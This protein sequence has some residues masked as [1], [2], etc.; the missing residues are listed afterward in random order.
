MVSKVN[1][2][3]R[4]ERHSRILKD[5]LWTIHPFRSMYH[6]LNYII[7]ITLVI[8]LFPVYP[9]F[10]SFF[11]ENSVY[12]F[13]RWD[14]DESTIIDSYSTDED[15]QNSSLVWSDNFLS[16]NTLMNSDRDL[17]G[18]NEVVDYEV[19]AWD[20]FSSL[21]YKFWVSNNSIL[22]ANNFDS[23]KVLHPWD[24]IKIPPVSGLIHQVKKWETVAALAKKYSIDEKKILSQN[25]INSWDTLSEW[26]VLII[27]GAIKKVEQPVVAKTTTKI[28]KSTSKTA[29]KSANSAQWW[30]AFT[31]W[32]DSEFIESDWVYE[33]VKRTPKWTFYRWNCTWYVA[34]YKNVDWSWN[35]NQWL[36]NARSKWHTTWSTPGVWSIVV[37]N[38]KWYNPRYWHVWIVIDVTSDSIIVRDM[39]YRRLNEVTVR[40]VPKTD[41]AIQWYIYVD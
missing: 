1:L 24:K 12:D 31:S 3:A 30:Y 40:K 25:S 15:T 34:Q 29:T 13:Y 28:T 38:W 33:L 14:I 5:N 2:K 26:V 21:A 27:P 35:A 10:S 18:Y 17:E 37:F 9:L 4:I 36:G 22:W 7:V 6:K 32:G 11:Y 41:R 39:N 20:S 23:K 16:I 8:F 19:Q